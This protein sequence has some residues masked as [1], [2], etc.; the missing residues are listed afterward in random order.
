MKLI[1]D[2]DRYVSGQPLTA[3]AALKLAARLES[4]MATAARGDVGLYEVA[5]ER[6]LAHL[7]RTAAGEVRVGPAREGR[8]L[9]LVRPP[10]G[11][12]APAATVAV[13]RLPE[14]LR[15]SVGAMLGLAEEAGESVPGL[16]VRP[17]DPAYGAVFSDMDA[18]ACRAAGREAEDAFDYERAA[19]AYRLAVVRSSGALAQVRELV[20]FLAEAYADYEETAEVLGSPAL[21]LARERDLRLSLANALFQ[22]GKYDGAREHYERL[23]KGE[24]DPFVLRRLGELALRGG[25]VHEARERL[26]QA[27]RLAPGDPEVRDLLGRCESAASGEADALLSEARARLDA[28]DLG[29][30]RRLVAQVA[31]RWRTHSGVERLRLAIDAAATRE[32]AAAMASEANRLAAVGEWRAAL[33][34]IKDALRHDEGL[35]VALSDL[36]G[37]A[38]RAVAA[39]DA[40]G[41][42]KAARARAAEGDLPGALGA[43][44]RAIET[45]V[46]LP[47][48]A[49]AEPLV[50]RLRR[51]LRRGKL[52][53]RAVEG[54]AA[55]HRADGFVKA[56]R[57]TEAEAALRDA[58]RHLKDDS[59]ARGIEA[60]IASIR[61]EDRRKEAGARLAEADKAEAAGDFAAALA[62]LERLPDGKGQDTSAR[63]RR[64]REAI[65]ANEAARALEA[66]LLKLADTGEW[67]RLRRELR[68]PGA[69]VAPALAERASA[70]IAAEWAVELL[71][72]PFTRT[73][74]TLDLA[75]LG[76]SADAD[77]LVAIDE[78][79]VIAALGD[80]LLVADLADLGVR[81]NLRLPAR[82]ALDR[83]TTRVFGADDR[84]HL[85]DC[86]TRTLTTLLLRAGGAEV[87]ERVDLD[88]GAPT[89]DEPH[90][91]AEESA[92]DA[93]TG[94]LLLLA[95]GPRQ[96]RLVSVS[97]E[98][99]QVRGDETFAFPMF[100]LRPIV[101]DPEGR[102]TVQRFLDLTKPQARFFSFAVVDARAKVLRKVLHADI[103]EPMHAIRRIAHIDGAAAPLL[104]QY[105]FINPFTGQVAQDSNALM[106]LRPDFDVFYHNSQP[107]LWLGDDRV[108]SGA[109]AVAQGVLVLPWRRHGKKGG[110][111][112]S[113][114]AIDRY[115][116]TWDLDVPEGSRLVGVLDRS[117]RCF[118]V[119]KS[120]L[121]TVVRAVDVAKGAFG[122]T[123]KT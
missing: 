7:L 69:P 117:G 80:R 29:E 94:R 120:A 52:D 109:F 22:L 78:R 56:G 14:D 100:A 90:R 19:A 84:L 18:A 47:E 65:A 91:M 82:L 121:G 17:V 11:R 114:L 89:F 44:L 36:S 25:R 41:H 39:E 123:T 108:I 38:E 23:L 28:G 57:L 93:A 79:R 98:D 31:E 60:A 46:A 101:G 4:E 88:R 27:V 59:D 48:E 62:A 10:T 64:L 113:G 73:P 8:E 6:V 32:K 21:D 43:W 12:R 68:A 74:G 103:E 24:A 54:L 40:A 106:Q 35:R 37:A 81:W 96:S 95:G 97:V 112:L 49:A 34:A 92:F 51:H 63:R 9:C 26:Q 110:D 66:R 53:G 77:P 2:A 116:K 3:E 83:K 107:D 118:A 71:P 102:F 13:V 61:E 105:W 20:R 76:L 67:W 99:G 87:V 85:L 45:G 86:R 70:A 15:A 50:Q 33:Q 111:G 119:L 1:E 104:A 16:H 122:T 42:V 5:R 30:A 75:Q 115:Q 55:L 58:R 72:P